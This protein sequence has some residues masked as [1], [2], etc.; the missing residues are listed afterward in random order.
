MAVRPNVRADW[1]AGQFN[2]QG[3]LLFDGGKLAYQQILATD[4]IINF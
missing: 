3:L 4:V 2:S 1:Y